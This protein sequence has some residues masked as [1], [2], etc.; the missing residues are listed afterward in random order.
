[1]KYVLLVVIAL[2]L[3]VSLSNA[4]TF[5]ESSQSFTKEITDSTIINIYVL[6]P[7]QWGEWYVSETL[8]TN[9]KGQWYRGTKFSYPDQLSLV[10]EMGASGGDDDSLAVWIQPL[11]WDEADDEF[12]EI[13]S[14]S[15]RLLLGAARD[16]SNGPLNYFDLTAATEYHCPIIRWSPLTAATDAI[17]WPLPGF[18]LHVRYVDANAGTPQL[19]LTINGVFEE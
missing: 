1:M 17:F 13:V 19:D 10:I 7:D 18:V 15:S 3:I 5:V 16:Y 14:D 11:S 4:K 6:F 9:V 8:P 2:F 12:A